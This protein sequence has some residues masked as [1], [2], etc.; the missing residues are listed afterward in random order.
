MKSIIALVFAALLIQS[1]SAATIQGKLFEWESL[2]KIE[3]AIIDVNSIPPQRVVAE[4]GDYRFTVPDG[5]YSIV[6][7]QFIKGKLARIAKETILV[8]GEGTFVMDLVLREATES[9]LG[10]V[11]GKG[12]EA[13]LFEETGESGGT[14]LAAF[15]FLAAGLATVGYGI[16]KKAKSRQGRE[17]QKHEALDKYAVEVLEI[18]RR[19]GNRLTQKELREKC[20]G[21]GEAKISLVLTELE[22]MGKIKKIKKGRGNIIILKGVDS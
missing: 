8:E 6:A 2:Q 9:D 14:I 12:F 21:C 11:Q 17:S 7:M 15:L 19:S 18:L 5:V 10:A 16:A 22:A 4:N 13:G 20:Q 1:C 3:S